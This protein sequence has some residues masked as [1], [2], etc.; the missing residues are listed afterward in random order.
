MAETLIIQVKGRLPLHS[1]DLAMGVVGGCSIETVLKVLVRDQASLNGLL[2]RLEDLG[3][4]LVEFR[5]L[6]PASDTSANIIV[7]VVVGGPLGD[8]AASILQDQLRITSMSTR[9][10][11]S[12]QDLMNQAFDRLQCLGA[13][14]EYATALESRPGPAPRVEDG[15]SI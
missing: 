4:N 1:V 14:V 13:E 6:S 10:T 3:L 9:V 2:R 12:D 7:E 5:R 11:F 8:L 15:G